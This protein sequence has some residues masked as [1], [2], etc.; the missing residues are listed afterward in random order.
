M[1]KKNLV[2]IEKMKNHRV[3]LN[4]KKKEQVKGK[5]ENSRLKV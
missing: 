5:I 4:R 3:E 2:Y 1:S